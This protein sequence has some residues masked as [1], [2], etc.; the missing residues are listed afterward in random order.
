MSAI[1]SFSGNNRFLSNF[2]PCPIE[3][4]ACEFDP[5]VEGVVVFATTEHAYQASKFDFNSEEWT[6]IFEAKTPGEAKRIANEHMPS[7]E[8]LEKRNDIMRSLLQKKFEYGSTCAWL[9]MGT[10]FRT[11]LIEGNKWGDTYW[12]RV[13]ND[14]GTL[15]EGQNILGRMLMNRRATLFTEFHEREC[16]F[17]QVGKALL[18]IGAE[19]KLAR[20]LEERIEEARKL[21]GIEV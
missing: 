12:G 18:A 7:Q 20:L 3:I 1:I 14:K 2:Y 17:T 8:F 13:F 9:L 11:E 19:N 15:A 21:A 16:E 6:R 4:S 10:G 5:R